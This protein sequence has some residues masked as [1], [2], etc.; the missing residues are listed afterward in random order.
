M[1]K[2]TRLHE[3]AS[4]VENPRT[5]RDAITHT[6]EGT[7]TVKDGRI[8]G[9]ETL[10]ALIEKLVEVQSTKRGITL[11]ESVRAQSYQHLDLGWIGDEIDNMKK[12]IG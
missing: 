7:L 8:E 10:T 5:L 9:K 11:L 2:F 6:I 12:I 1:K 4:T 3:E